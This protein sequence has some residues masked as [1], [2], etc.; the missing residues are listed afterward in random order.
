MPPLPPH[1]EWEQARSLMAAL[2]KGD[3]GAKDIVKQ[4][5][6]GKVQEFLPHGR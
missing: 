1:V 2:L 3:P 4:G 5:F 6:K